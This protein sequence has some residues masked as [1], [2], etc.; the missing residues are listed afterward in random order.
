[1]HLLYL[2][3]FYGSFIFLM[4]VVSQGVV[5]GRSVTYVCKSKLLHMPGRA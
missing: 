4:H 5:D 1:M 2:V 3:F